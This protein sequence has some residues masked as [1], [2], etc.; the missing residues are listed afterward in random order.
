MG[1]NSWSE[2]LGKGFNIFPNK[3]LGKRRKKY[4]H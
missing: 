1:R 4:S 3:A 2:A